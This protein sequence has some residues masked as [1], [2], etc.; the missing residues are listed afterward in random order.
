ME[1]HSSY[2]RL[3]KTR[4]LQLENK[5]SDGGAIGMNVMEK[6]EDGIII[7]SSKCQEPGE[8]PGDQPIVF[9]DYTVFQMPALGRCWRQN[10]GLN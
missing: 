8:K 9:V 7:C 10:V 6:G 1:R 3:N 4:A 2:M 5:M